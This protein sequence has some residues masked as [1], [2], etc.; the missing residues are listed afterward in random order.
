MIAA[1]LINENK[2]SYSLN[3]V[4]KEYLAESKNEFLLNETAAQWG[5]NPKSRDV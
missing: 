4:S 2:F 1:P 3:A 5:V